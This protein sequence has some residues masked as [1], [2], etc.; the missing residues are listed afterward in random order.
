MQYFTYFMHGAKRKKK[1]QVMWWIKE[2]TWVY[3]YLYMCICD[4]LMN[5]LISVCSCLGVCNCTWVLQIKYQLCSPSVTCQPHRG[6][7]ASPNKIMTNPPPASNTT[8]PPLTMTVFALRETVRRVR[9]EKW[10]VGNRSK[11]KLGSKS[12]QA[13]K[14]CPQSSFFMTVSSQ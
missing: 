7:Q 3:C 8:I 4:S 9:G 6:Q 5:V 12:C 11:E 14:S 10:V 2:S 13:D 1:T